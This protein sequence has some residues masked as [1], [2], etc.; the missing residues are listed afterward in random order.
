MVNVI[1]GI[2]G[3][4]IFVIALVT[5]FYLKEEKREISGWICGRRSIWNCSIFPRKFNRCHTDRLHRSENHI[6]T[7][8]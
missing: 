4:I 7:G 8:R 1:L 3:A 2:V 5:G 6:R